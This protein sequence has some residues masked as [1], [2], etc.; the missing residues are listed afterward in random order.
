MK[1]VKSEFTQLHFFFFQQIRRDTR[2]RC[3]M[4]FAFGCPSVFSLPTQVTK[5]PAPVVAVKTSPN[6]EYIAFLTSNNLSIWS[7]GKVHLKN[8][9]ILFTSLKHTLFLGD[10]KFA[11]SDPSLPNLCLDLFWTNPGTELVVVVSSFLKTCHVS[12]FSELHF[13]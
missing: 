7:G 5:N 6:D 4:Y 2:D 8:R 12:D 13:L 11:V 10:Y 9:E 3:H 1:S